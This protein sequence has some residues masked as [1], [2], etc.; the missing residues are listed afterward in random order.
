M[1]TGMT[2]EAVADELR[3]EE[4]RLGE[5]ED[6]LRR[7]EQERTAGEIRAVAGALARTRHVLAELPR[8]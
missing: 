3:R 5:I 7:I 6:R 4:H 2:I 1:E 8:G